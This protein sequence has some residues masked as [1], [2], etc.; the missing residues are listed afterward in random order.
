M[1]H[2]LTVFLPLVFVLTISLAPS[3]DTK[4]QCPKAC[5]TYISSEVDAKFSR[6]VRVSTHSLVFLNF[7]G[8]NFITQMIFF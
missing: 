8:V 5:R 2:V 4:R 6:T 1:A 7:D 3:V